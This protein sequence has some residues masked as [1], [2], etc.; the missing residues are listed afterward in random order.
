[1]T[2]QQKFVVKCPCNFRFSKKDLLVNTFNYNRNYYY[3][4]YWSGVSERRQGAASSTDLLHLDIFEHSSFSTTTP[5]FMSIFPIHIMSSHS[6]SILSFRHCLRIYFY[7]LQVL[8]VYVWRLMT[9]HHS[10]GE[11]FCFYNNRPIVKKIIILINIIISRMRPG[12]CNLRCFRPK[13]IY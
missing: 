6:F 13:Y 12:R 10:T 1:M 3:Y 5:L 4:Y 9:P 2:V 7:A 11:T 8:D